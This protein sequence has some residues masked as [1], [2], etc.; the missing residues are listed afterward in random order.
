M[1][2]MSTK[3]KAVGDIWSSG[4]SYRNFLDLCDEAGGR[5]TGTESETKARDLIAARL[6]DYGLSNVHLEPVDYLSWKRIG[7]KLKLAYP[8][9]RDLDSLA[10][11]YSSP[12]PQEGLETE[13]VFISEPTRDAFYDASDRVDGRAVLTYVGNGVGPACQST[14][15]ASDLGAEA[16][17]LM[18]NS[19]RSMQPAGSCRWNQ[20]SPI[21]VMSIS[22]E[23]GEYINRIN[24][25][26][27][28]V[29]VRF[30]VESETSEGISH[31]VVADIPGRERQ[32][33]QVIIGA[34]Y[35]GFDIAQSAIDNASGTAT[36]MEAARALSQNRLECERTL[37]FVL[38]A[39]EELGMVGS[40]G[41]L[42]A[43][44]AETDDISVM[45]T[46][47]WPG[48]PARYGLQ[49]PFTELEAPLGSSMQ[50]RGEVSTGLGMY[51]DHFP[52]MRK[53]VPTMW[54][55]GQITG[56]DLEIYHT[57][58]DTADKVPPRVLQDSAMLI[59][60]AA[61]DL[62]KVDRPA[63][64][65]TEG[66]IGRLLEESGRTAALKDEGRWD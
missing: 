27:G 53:G 16:L 48:Y 6:D 46:T 58:F 11:T 60:S 10:F 26:H 20:P 59:T 13:L 31:N 30:T 66:E 14:H 65:R 38:F 28:S 45:M 9:N 1:M 2:T 44:K 34:H 49:L 43:H 61:V 29:T 41:Y 19:Y 32:D 22:R 17:I 21:P 54:I 36:V 47:D 25:A 8:M 57:V 3:A 40:Q 18:A 51:S 50:G 24:D 12:T 15:W 55:G 39:A 42:D 7:A 4:E 52:F 63:E 64:H 33:E 5:F 23:D 56:R 62:A 37:R 35:D